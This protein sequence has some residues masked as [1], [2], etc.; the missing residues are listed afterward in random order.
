MRFLPIHL[1]T[2]GKTILIFGGDRAAEAKLRTLVKS[3]AHLVL[4]ADRISAEIQNWIEQ[5]NIVRHEGNLERLDLSNVILVYA[6]TEDD[7]ENTRIAK[8]AATQGIIVNAADYKAACDF[9]S[10]AIVDRSPVV[11]SIGTEGTSPAL[12]RAIKADLEQRLPSTLGNI[13]N[14]LKDLRKKVSEQF[15]AVELRQRFWASLIP[16]GGLTR[17]TALSEKT[18]DENVQQLLSHSEIEDNGLGH[19]SLVGAGPGA[20]GLLTLEAQQ[21]LHAADV[22]IYD[23]LVGQDVLDLGRR[24]AKYIYVGKTPNGTSITQDEINDLIVAEARK[25]HTVIRLKGGDPL[26]FGRADE[27]IDAL[28]SAGIS[29]DVVPGI[30]AAAASAA[31]AGVSLTT[32]GQ[33]KAVGL[34]TGHD[35]KGFAEHDWSALARQDARMAIYMGVGAARFIQGRLLLYGASEKKP[36]IVVEKASLHDQKIVQTTIENLPQDIEN[37]DIKGPAILLIGYSKNQTDCQVN[38]PKRAAS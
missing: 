20:L 12:A 4:F 26:I 1:D 16:A 30:T 8:W 31:T 3:D 19:V 17:F 24:E 14:K 22:I 34:M 38:A 7:Q 33:N 15:G 36:V 2:Q 32:R 18:I 6:A 29:F 23:R 9:Y 25:G 11:I 28:K 5:G 21:K 35:S 37:N 10:P 13:A 27:E